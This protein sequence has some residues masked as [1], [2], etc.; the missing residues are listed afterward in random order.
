LIEFSNKVNETADT[1]AT[2]IKD[3][4]KKDALE[5]MCGIYRRQLQYYV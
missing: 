3:I 5:K 1:I 4:L 2:Y